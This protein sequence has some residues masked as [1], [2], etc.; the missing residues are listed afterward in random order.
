MTVFKVI[1][2]GK[3]GSLK[4]KFILSAFLKDTRLF[5]SD[6]FTK[7][8]LEMK[9]F[10]LSAACML[11]FLLVSCTSVFAQHEKSKT[12]G[13]VTIVRKTVS[14]DGT[15]SIRKTRLDSGQSLMDL[16]RA[17]GSGTQ[18]GDIDVTLIGDESTGG[19]PFDEEVIIYFRKAGQDRIELNFDGMDDLRKELHSL[20]ITMPHESDFYF[21]GGPSNKAFMG[22]YPETGENGVR[23]TGIVSGTGAAEAGLQTGDVM[24]DINGNTIRTNRDLSVELAKYQPGDV[25]EVGYL[26]NGSGQVVSV[27][28]TQSRNSFTFQRDPCK[29]FFG[30]YVGGY[31]HGRQ[32]V[33]VSGIVTGND[34]PAEVAGLQS[35]DRIIMIDGVPVNSHRELVAGRDRHE[36]GE[37]FTFTILRDGE[38]FDVEAQFKSCP[39]DEELAVV[40]EVLP[41]LP[42]QPNHNLQLEEL[43]AYPNPTFGNLNLSFKGEAV[44]ANIRITDVNGR[45]VYEKQLDDF[46]GYFS[47]ELDV[48]KGTPG[49]L[50]VT[51]T[52]A[53]QMVTEP[54][55]LLNR[56]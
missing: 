12:P 30:V 25:V 28:L 6:L 45:V 4:C 48:S 2:K 42:V 22:V 56:A 43:K 26:R 15:V 27:K 51:I 20:H 3:R 52:Q 40:E 17:I 47:Q 14:D 18:P 39:K 54:V 49:T 46:G 1:N 5:Q 53:G 35:G 7:K 44:P 50:M 34:W 41:E 55:V 36:S 29:V 37:S 11:A 16:S 32:G 10:Y 24:T 33:G 31:G 13:T 21:N 8:S 38:E 23:L 9:R 19:E